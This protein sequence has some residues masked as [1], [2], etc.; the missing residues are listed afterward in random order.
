ML[1]ANPLRA[2]VLDCVTDFI[3]F[4]GRVL[5][6]VGVGI[7]G[8]F[9]FSKSFSIDPNYRKYFEPDLHYYWV[10]LL[11]VILGAYFISKTFFTVF[12][13][14]A[15]TVF[16]CAMKDLSVHDGTPEKPYFMSTK[17]LKILDAKNKPPE[18]KP[19]EDKKESW[20]LLFGLK[21]NYFFV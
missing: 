1:A 16:L 14:A 3:L 13:M 10:P 8:F 21:K 19:D 6:T 7:L 9:F 12:E 2:V 5:I 4:L 17:L 20:M 11:C 18:T 15:D